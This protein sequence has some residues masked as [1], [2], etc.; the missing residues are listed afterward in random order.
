[1]LRY[2]TDKI[3]QKAGYGEGKERDKQREEGEKHR[4]TRTLRMEEVYRKDWI[5]YT[6][7]YAV[8]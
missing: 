5:D 7:G 6:R 3:G 4:E 1:M 2:Y 8:H